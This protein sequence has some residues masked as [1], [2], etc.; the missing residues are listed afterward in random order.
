M[1]RAP[2][3][4]RNAARMAA[5][6]TSRL[7]RKIT[8][9]LARAVRRAAMRT[10]RFPKWAVRRDRRAAVQASGTSNNGDDA[11]KRW[12]GGKEA[13]CEKTR[14]IGRAGSWAS[15]WKIGIEA[16]E[17]AMDAGMRASDCRGCATRLAC[18]GS[19]V[20]REGEV[21]SGLRFF[22][23]TLILAVPMT[24]TMVNLFS[25]SF[26]PTEWPSASPLG[27]KRLRRFR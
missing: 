16:V 19:D 13:A 27:K 21:E 14:R 1:R 12:R 7:S 18:W 3:W 23:D 4:Q 15:V 22:V 6:L 2:A 25:G 20:L 11:K 17:N 8:T 26:F 24:P 9:A 10:G 5:P